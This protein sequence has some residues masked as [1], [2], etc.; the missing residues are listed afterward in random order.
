MIPNDIPPYEEFYLLCLLFQ[1]FLLQFCFLKSIF[2]GDI[3][4]FTV[5][6]NF[7][8]GSFLQW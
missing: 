3:S 8:F 1:Y 2:V 4:F 7:R 6:S 5:Y